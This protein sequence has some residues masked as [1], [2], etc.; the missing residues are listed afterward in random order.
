MKVTKLMIANRVTW[1]LL[2][3]IKIV[4]HNHH[5]TA[6]LHRT[7][8]PATPLPLYYK[9]RQLALRSLIN[10]LNM[11]R[12]AFLNQEQY[13]Q[14]IKLKEAILNTKMYITKVFIAF[15]TDLYFYMGNTHEVCPNR[16]AAFY[17]LHM[18]H[19]ARTIEN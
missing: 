9:L 11:T 16:T 5:I 17:N 18:F 14:R 10:E 15:T 13:R 1:P 8:L 2:G 3:M 6:L 19:A 12:L 7:L 4:N